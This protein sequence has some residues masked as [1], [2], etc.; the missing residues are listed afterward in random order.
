MNTRERIR[1]TMAL[2]FCSLH[3]VSCGQDLTVFLQDRNFG[4][5]PALKIDGN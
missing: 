3:Q 1:E 5:L 4:H 2:L